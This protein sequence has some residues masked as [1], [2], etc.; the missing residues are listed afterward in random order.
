VNAFIRSRLGP[1]NRVSLLYVPRE[2]GTE[3]AEA[4]DMAAT[5][6]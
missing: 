2:E 5:G 4:A 3:S 1:D 6:V